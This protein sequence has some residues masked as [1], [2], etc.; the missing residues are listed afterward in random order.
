MATQIYFGVY[1]CKSTPVVT[2]MTC[3]EGKIHS[4][5]KANY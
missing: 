2:R 1:T 3:N 5:E 4:K